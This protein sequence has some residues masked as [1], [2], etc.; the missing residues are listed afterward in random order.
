MELLKRIFSV[1]IH[2]TRI[3]IYVLGIKIKLRNYR[4]ELKKLKKRVNELDYANQCRIAKILP[5]TSIK[6]IEIH[7]TDHCNLKC[8]GCHHFAPL[9]SQSFR[10]LEE[11]ERDLTRLCALT[12]GKV[13]TFNILGGEP[14]L[15]PQCIEFL[16][17]ARRIFPKSHIKLVTNG[18]LLPEQTDSFYERCAESDILLQPTKYG[19]EVDWEAVEEKCRKFGVDFEFY[20]T[21]NVMWKDPIDLT[22]SQRAEYSFLNCQLG[23]HEVFYLDHGKL[24]HCSKT[25]YLKFFSDYFK[26]DIKV[27]ETDCIDIYKVKDAQEIYDFMTRPPQFC[28][29]CVKKKTLPYYPWELSKKDITEWVDTDTLA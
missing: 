12:K 17:T 29:Y 20:A 1:H 23:W 7:I 11:F 13:D 22:G 4:K 2:G 3:L 19:V 16:E 27:P 5:V 26:K 8:K 24:Y 18:I 28:A 14:L 25:A 6:K 9:V 21:N 10:D 15:H